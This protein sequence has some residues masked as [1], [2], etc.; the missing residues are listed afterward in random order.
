M[1]LGSNWWWGHM[2]EIVL[3]FG[4]NKDITSPNS[5]GFSR[6]VGICVMAMWNTALPQPTSS[7][8]SQILMCASLVAHKPHIS[9]ACAFSIT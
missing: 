3:S 5:T 9:S 1:S 7:M 6:E 4:E 8:I 2:T